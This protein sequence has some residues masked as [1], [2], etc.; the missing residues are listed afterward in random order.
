MDNLSEC[1]EAL[2]GVRRNMQHDA[3]S[4][5]PA[6]DKAIAELERIAAGEPTEHDVMCAVLGALAVLSKILACA[7]DIEK[8]VKSFGG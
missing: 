6:L 8:L 4:C 5:V 7:A 3:D 1:V 2:K